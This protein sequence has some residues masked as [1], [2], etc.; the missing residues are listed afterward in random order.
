MRAICVRGWGWGLLADQALEIEREIQSAVD[1]LETVLEVVP[2]L[3][4]GLRV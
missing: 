2:T 1:R 4:P 3:A